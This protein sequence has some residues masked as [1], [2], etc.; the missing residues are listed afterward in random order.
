MKQLLKMQTEDIEICGRI[1]NEV[2][3]SKYNTRTEQSFIKYFSPFITDYDK[4]AYVLKENECILGFVTAVIKPSVLED[5][6]IY[7][8]AV[9]ISPEYQKQGNGTYMLDTFMKLFSENVFIELQTKKKIPAYKMYKKM[10]FALNNNII[11]IYYNSKTAGM[12]RWLEELREK[13]GTTGE[14]TGGDL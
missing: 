6:V 14:T 12:I 10:G 7:V 3:P 9:A 5:E 11:S 8:D 4:Y 13:N 1:Y 2:F